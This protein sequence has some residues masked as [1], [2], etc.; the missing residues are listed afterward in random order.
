MVIHFGWTWNFA[1]HFRRPIIKALNGPNYSKVQ[2]DDSSSSESAFGE[3]TH[4]IDLETKE[5]TTSLDSQDSKKC[6]FC[7]ESINVEAIKCKH[8][9]S[10]LVPSTSDKVSAFLKSDNGKIVSVISFCFL[11][12]I[13]GFL[14]I[15]SNEAKELKQLSQNG[16]VCVY[17]DLEHTQDY[18]CS[19][20]PNVAFGYCTTAKVLAPFWPDRDFESL[21]LEGS[22]DVG[23]I[24]GTVGGK[25]GD[26]CSDPSYPNFFPYRWKTDFGVGTYKLLAVEYEDL[27]SDIDP[28]FSGAGEFIVEI[29]IKK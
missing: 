7:A 12:A 28:P 13:S 10:S 5:V 14:I 2:R 9:G 23:R 17:S 24:Q 6:K 16:Q 26:I 11:L 8:C 29:S 15:E 18:G 20:Y 3:G 1:F 19:T 25:P 22:N 4:Q 27:E 21:M